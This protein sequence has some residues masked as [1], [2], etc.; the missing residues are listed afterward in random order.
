MIFLLIKKDE[1]D[2]KED[3][4]SDEIKKGTTEQSQSVVKKPEDSSSKEN[5]TIKKDQVT[6]DF[7]EN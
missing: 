7:D 3:S 2:S 4:N 5:P 1:P 6:F